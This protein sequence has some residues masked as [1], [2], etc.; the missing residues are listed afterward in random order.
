[1]TEG[2]KPASKCAACGT[3]LM[4]HPEDPYEGKTFGLDIGR[5]GIRESARLLAFSRGKSGLQAEVSAVADIMRDR[6]SRKPRAV[7]ILKGR[8]LRYRKVNLADEPAVSKNLLKNVTAGLRDRGFIPVMDRAVQSVTPAVFERLF[9]NKDKKLYAI[10]TFGADGKADVE[11]IASAPAGEKMVAVTNRPFDW[12]DDPGKTTYRLP[13]AQVAELMSAMEYRSPEKSR[14]GLKFSLKDFVAV[15]ADWS[16]SRFD[17]AESKRLIVKVR[18]EEKTTALRPGESQT[19]PECH[20]HPGATAVS[21]CSACSK[22]L[23]LACGARM[24]GKNL[25]PSCLPKGAVESDFPFDISGD[26]APAGFFLRAGVKVAEIAGLIAIFAA[27]FPSGA[28]AGSIIAFQFIAALAFIAYFT[29]PM[30]AWGA[31]PFQRIAGVA[32][33]DVETGDIPSVPS[34][35]ARSGYLFLTMLT[36]I[37]AIGYLAVLRSPDR[38]GVHD[39]IAG[40]I[41]LTRAGAIKEKAGAVALVLALVVCGSALKNGGTDALVSVSGRAFGGVAPLG[42]VELTAKWRMNGVKSSAYN[43]HGVSAGVVS[44]TLTGFDIETGA[45]VWK[46]DGV[47]AVSVHTDTGSGAYVF[48]GM[49]DNAPV[50]GAVSWRLGATVWMAQMDRPSQTPPVFISAGV[51][52]ADDRHIT[53]FGRTGKKLW[54]KDAGG[55]IVSISAVGDAVVAAL[56]GKGSVVFDAKTGSLLAETEGV[57]AVAGPEALNLFT[58]RGWTKSASFTR[59]GGREW[60]LARR[61]SF[62]T[63]ETRAGEFYYARETVVRAVDGAIVFDYPAGCV[64][65]GMVKNS[66]ALSCPMEK[67]LLLADGVSGRTLAS[68]AAPPL[69]TVRLIGAEGGGR[70]LA[71]AKTQGGFTR[72]YV[73]LIKTGFTELDVKEVG[74]FRNKP[75]IMNLADR[76]GLL[77]IAGDGGMGLYDPAPGKTAKK[78]GDPIL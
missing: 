4:E 74:E 40:T 71:T 55:R 61:L 63:E 65:V 24:N 37:P 33:V 51:A 69:D 50:I 28:S 27:L 22:P 21:L 76:G 53:V 72:V 14:Q 56:K 45:P 26:L 70:L 32:V 18:G 3:V 73:L 6:I 77:F 7:P 15:I 54:S 41:V 31:T 5:L 60:R 17:A 44:E 25:C 62:A 29:I 1:M 23:C 78:A 48:T 75:V 36:F 57:P 58:G 38:R 46:L 20:Y 19:A 11:I 35:L 68:F 10:A 66:A 67:K 9:A 43:T 59:E 16:E 47:K 12:L 49:K 8:L 42:R 2:A 34:A 30:A 64:C 39:R 13:G 52:V